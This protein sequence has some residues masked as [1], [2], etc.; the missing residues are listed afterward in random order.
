M[1]LFAYRVTKFTRSFLKIVL[2]CCDAQVWIV[3]EECVEMNG[4]GTELQLRGIK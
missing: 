4:S 3:S 1:L 2:L